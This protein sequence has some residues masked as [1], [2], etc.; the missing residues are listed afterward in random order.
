[1]KFHLTDRNLPRYHLLGTLIVVVTLAL[2]LG[3]SFL[4]IGVNQHRQSIDRLEHSFSTQK[5]E[6]LRSEMAAAI[7]YL[8]FVHSRTEMVLQEALRDRVDMAMQTAQAIYDREHGHR[9]EAEVKRLIVEALRPQRFYDGRGYFFIDGLD[10][11]C[12]LLP[13]APER[14][15]GSL[16]NN[17]DDTGHYIMRG[18][19]DTAR[20][21]PEGGYSAYRWYSPDNPREMSDK[22][23]YVRQFKPF[24]WVIGTGDYLYKWQD[25][26]MREGLE[27]LRAWKFGDTGSFIAISQNGQLLLQPQWP[28]FEGKHF[29]EVGTQEEQ[30][31]R[32]ALIK[33]ASEGGGFL[34]Y[35]WPN[36][37]K[38]TQ[39]LRT[40]YVQVY[41]PWKMIVIASVFEEEM[42]GTF[43]AEREATLQALSRQ[44]PFL[45]AAA[46]TAIMLAIGAS[47]LFSRWMSG[48]LGN[49]RRELDEHAQALEKQAQQLRLAGHVFESSKEGI[50]ITDPDSR[51]L[52]VNPAFC[53]IT[54]RTPN[55]VVGQRPSI[56]ASGEHD[57]AFYR[58]MWKSI[59]ET[60]SWTGEIRNRRKDGAVYPELISISS[61]RDQTGK[62]LHYVGTFLDITE[63]KEAEEQIR[64][65]A[66]Y[67]PLTQLPNRSLL[68]ERLTD[69]VAQARREARQLGVLFID[70]DRFKN[71]N[72]S[73]GHPIGDRVLQAVADRLRHLVQES[74]TVSRLGGDEFAVVLTH[75][76]GPSRVLPAARKILS[77]LSQPYYID[78]HELQLTPSIG[79]TLF[80]DNGQDS[81]TLLKNADTAMYHA[82]N[83][84][85]NNFQFFTP[86][87]NEWVMERLQVEN[88][89][90]HALARQELILHYQPQVDLA[91]GNIV[92]CEALLRWL[93]TGGALVPPDRFIPIAEE[94]GLIHSM[95]TWVLDEACRQLRAWDT[96]GA[97]PIDMAVNVAVPQLRQR[98]FVGLVRDTLQR[99]GL[100]PQRLEIEVT[101]SVFLNHDEQI[102][103]TLQGLADLGVQLS[104]DDFGTGYSSLSYLRNF[105]FDVLKID[106]SF[107]SELQCNQDDITLIR[108]IVSI[109]RDM[110]LVT[111]AEGIESEEQQ[112]ILHDLGCTIGQGYHFSRPI[113]AEQMGKLISALPAGADSIVD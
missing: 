41:R 42:Q 65:L 106:K 95:G 96:E 9:P 21:K 14:E 99:H 35:P 74:D 23:A 13:I 101:E 81:E 45:S 85:R 80:P 75:L 93:P 11:E 55:E 103:E 94:T 24:G 12:I 29:M 100:N 37:A 59:R 27:R 6:R 113:V 61:V 90:R 87:F 78:E 39:S 19:A 69:A 67:D 82:K 58:N 8:D 109:A 68:S 15:G 40:A 34:E 20:S 28:E 25:M 56:L 60:G 98:N 7:G 88:G 16:W 111:V 54:G 92:G 86:E 91:S 107:V 1:M 63:R 52:A 31:V 32:A 48:L 64:Q 44:I 22:L 62:V 83:N 30:K 33:V 46:L 104:L 71:I 38:N 97:R 5:Q 110:S 3:A 84:G 79:I 50:V 102:R 112:R 4:W 73:L 10:G 89:L 47:V 43:N 76:D 77:A 57:A 70:L 2:M 51:I 72:D 66:E 36:R 105:R 26:R 49:Y 108:A 18:L 17:Q 53:A